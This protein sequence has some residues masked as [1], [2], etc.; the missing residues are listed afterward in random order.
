MK[1]HSERTCLFAALRHVRRRAFFAAV[2]VLPQIAGLFLAAFLG[3]CKKEG[4]QVREA[5]EQVF[6]YSDEIQGREPEAVMRRR[7]PKDV[8]RVR[9]NREIFNRPRLEV[10]LDMD[11]DAS[12][13]RIRSHL[14]K[15]TTMAMAGTA[16][17]AVRVRAWP[18]K[19]R[20]YG[21]IMGVSVLSP[22]GG[23]WASE[24]VGYRQL[25]ITLNTSN[26]A[27]TPTKFEHSILVELEA[28]HAKLLAEAR[29]QAM[30]ERNPEKIERI[31]VKLVATRKGLTF[32]SV[33]RIVSAARNYYLQEP[34]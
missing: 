34:F 4:K 18:S 1:K 9:D 10:E 19:L 25:K 21:G 15:V 29:Y 7:L 28:E 32:E 14:Q 22:D 16:Y 20:R 31:V 24:R 12:P 8:W 33:A 30:Q 17:K 27:K 11:Y 2:G 23:G 13:E 26:E 5:Y 6:K 3:A